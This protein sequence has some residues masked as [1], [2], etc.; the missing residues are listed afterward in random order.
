LRLCRR[1]RAWYDWVGCGLVKHSRTRP[2]EADWIDEV[3]RCTELLEAIVADHSTLS[4]LDLDLRARLLT[5]AGRVA[6]PE[7][8]SRRRLARACR[9]RERDHVRR[10][11]EAVLERT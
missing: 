2:T 6:R 10:S 9:K 4:V 7:P 8:V 5:A 11:D 1:C 3:A